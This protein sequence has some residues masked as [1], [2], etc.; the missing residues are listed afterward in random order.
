[1]KSLARVTWCAGSQ[2]GAAPDWAQR[3]ALAGAPFKGGAAGFGAVAKLRLA[4]CNESMSRKWRRKLLKSLKT[5]A[6]MAPV[7][8][9]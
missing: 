2:R 7:R 6:E 8:R 3:L 4:S 5:D 1:M 9:L